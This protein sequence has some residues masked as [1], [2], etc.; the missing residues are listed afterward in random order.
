MYE[1]QEQRSERQ[2]RYV[3]F[4]QHTHMNM[5]G[6]SLAGW[7]KQLE[8]PKAQQAA[9]N[10][11]RGELGMRAKLTPAHKLGDE[12]HIERAMAKWTCQQAKLEML[13]PRTRAAAASSTYASPRGSVSS[14]SP[15][16]SPRQSS[17]MSPRRVEHGVSR[18]PHIQMEIP[19]KR[20]DDMALINEL[21]R[22]ARGSD[23]PGSWGPPS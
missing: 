7:L 22:R 8:S 4:D 3:P 5:P 20:H 21:S 14:I 10:S 9:I 16:S 19:W 18:V 13:S 15:A 2:K 6:T 11:V 12:N 1:T 23:G 17:T